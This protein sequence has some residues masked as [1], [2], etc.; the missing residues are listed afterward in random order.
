MLSEQSASLGDC[1]LDRYL[2]CRNSVVYS[3]IVGDIVS[4]N[5]NIM[6]SRIEKLHKFVIGELTLGRHRAIIPFM[7]KETEIIHITSLD[8]TN[9][10]SSQHCNEIVLEVSR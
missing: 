10:H 1:I 4:S 2:V 7:Q 5:Y 6:A 8:K 3:N 9:K